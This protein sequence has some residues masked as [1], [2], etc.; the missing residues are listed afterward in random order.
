MRSSWISA[1]SS[2]FPEP[3]AQRHLLR[4][5][6][7]A[8]VYSLVRAA[9]P[10]EDLK[11]ERGFPHAGV[12]TDE[13]HLARDEA[14]AEHPVELLHAARHP[15]RVARADVGEPLELGAFRDA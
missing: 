3:R 5:F 9:Y 6:L 4:G 8:Y 11:E 12:A 14:A 2:S 1:S 13:H 10:G 7:A 15:R